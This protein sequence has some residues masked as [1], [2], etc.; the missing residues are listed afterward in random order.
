MTIKT[1]NFCFEVIIIRGLESTIPE[2]RSAGL[3][4]GEA[5]NRTS[6]SQIEAGIG[7][8]LDNTKSR[9]LE[10]H[11]SETSGLYPVNVS[12]WHKNPLGKF[13]ISSKFE[14]LKLFA[15]P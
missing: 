10:R 11:M 5:G 3:P 12:V 13:Y 14:I 2:G 9:I 15:F 1:N 8:E 4:I 6:Y 7:A